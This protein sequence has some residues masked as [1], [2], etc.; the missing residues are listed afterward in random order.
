V[1]RGDIVPVSGAQFSE[2]LA[3]A[4]PDVLGEMIWHRSP[5]SARQTGACLALAVPSRTA[6][7]ARRGPALPRPSVK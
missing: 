7:I 2:T 5:T 3:S 6:D 1:A 4:S